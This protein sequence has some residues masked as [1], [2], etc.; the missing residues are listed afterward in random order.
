METNNNRDIEIKDIFSLSNGIVSSF[1]QLTYRFIRFIFKHKFILILL[2]VVGAAGGY[3]LQ[4]TNNVYENKI[5]LIPNFGSVNYVYNKID[6]INSK[7]KEQ[8]EDFLKSIGLNDSKHILQVEIEPIN[9]VYRFVS[10][11]QTNFELLRLMA[12]DVSMAKVLDDPTT[13]KNYPYHLVTLSTK[14]KTSEKESVRPIVD[15]LNSS[16]YYEQIQKQYLINL[17]NKITANNAVIADIDGILKNF[18]KTTDSNKSGN[19]VYYNENTQLNDVIKSR[20]DFIAEQGAL[21]LNRID[22]T[23]VVRDS[24]IVLNRKDL[25]GLSNYFIIILPFVLIA[26]YISLIIVIKIVKKAQN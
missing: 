11:S 24:S 12:E 5:I 6:L 16:E 18:S 19:L 20:N 15:Y 4:K 23:K 8:D 13:S 14:G 26:L 7:I 3:L 2:F 17:E 9:D 21:K 22:F 25:S 10:S 1:V